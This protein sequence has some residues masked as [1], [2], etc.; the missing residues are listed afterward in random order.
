MLT[1]GELGHTDLTW[2]GMDPQARIVSHQGPERH[3]HSTP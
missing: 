3:H 1:V 2:S